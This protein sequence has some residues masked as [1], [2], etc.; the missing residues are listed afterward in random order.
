MLAAVVGLVEAQ[1]AAGSTAAA[2]GMA[3]AEEWE[4]VVVAKASAATGWAEAEEAAEVGSA[5]KAGAW[6]ELAAAATG[7]EEVA[8]APGWSRRRRRSRAR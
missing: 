6:A 7:M 8:P 3:V 4:R 1:A 2:V 5:A